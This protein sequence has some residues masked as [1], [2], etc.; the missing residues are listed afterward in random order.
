M[1]LGAGTLIE[2]DVLL[3][4]AAGRS[5]ARHGVEIGTSAIIRRGS[6]VHE[7]VRAGDRLELGV[8]AVIRADTSL[9]DD[10]RVSD[11]TIVDSGCTIGNGVHI[12]AHCYIARFSTIEDYVGIAPGVCLADDPHPGSGSHLCRRGPTIKRGA[13]IGLNAT[14]LPFVTIGERSLVGAGSVVTHDVPAGMVVAG[15][16]ARVLK[17][18]REVSCPLDLERGAYLADDDAMQHAGRARLRSP[19]VAPSAPART[20]ERG[21]AAH[22]TG[23]ALRASPVT[24]GP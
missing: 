18:V 14:V 17:S 23:A 20:R 13:Q 1:R 15:N 19:N 2:S 3:G 16:P 8:N 24:P 6:S 5:E 10:C 22:P 4:N 9:G 11:N 12:D 21:L 7:G